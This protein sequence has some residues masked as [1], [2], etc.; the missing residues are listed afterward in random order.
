VTWYVQFV[1]RF[2]DV[3]DDCLDRAGALSTLPCTLE[4]GD[5]HAALLFAVCHKHRAAVEQSLTS[6]KEVSLWCD[7]C[8]S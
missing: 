6:Y 5:A 2:V 7:A 8:R 4:D 1:T 3:P